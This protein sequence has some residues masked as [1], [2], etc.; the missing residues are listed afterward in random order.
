MQTSS[1]GRPADEVIAGFEGEF[2][3]YQLRMRA[4]G[5]CF[6]RVNA[7][8]SYDDRTGELIGFS[9]GNCQR[10]LGHAPPCDTELRD[11]ADKAARAAWVQRLGL[12]TS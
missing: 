11:E 2:N 4:E 8:C 9:Y 7:S 1:S 5:L 3:E 6:T 10:R 12:V